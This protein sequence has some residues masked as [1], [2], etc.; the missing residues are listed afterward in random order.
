V[1]RASNTASIIPAGP[2]PTTHTSASY[3]VTMYC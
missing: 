1:A 3:E 2:P